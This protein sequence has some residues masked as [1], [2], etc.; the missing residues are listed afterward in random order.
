VDG[1]VERRGALEV[2]RVAGFDELGADVIVTTR[3]GGVSAPPYET[4]NLGDHVG[5]EP[6][7]VR[8]NRRRLASAMGVDLV[9]LA[10]ARQVHGTGVALLR[11]G[12]AHP[13]P[14]GDADVIVTDDA[15]LAIGVLVA[16]CVPIVVLDPV[17]GV[18][19]VAHAG[20]RGTA[21]RVAAVA[22]ETMAALGARPERC[23]AA[24]GPCISA[25]AYQVGEEV[26][27]ALR[28]AGCD[29]S[30]VPDGEGRYHADLATATRTHLI[31]AGLRSEHVALPTA[32][33]DDGTV[34]FSDR[35]ERPCGR[36][37]LAARLRAPSS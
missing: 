13:A 35:A 10:I 15:S 25:R 14:L 23:R 24:M 9:D 7:A 4:L 32:W 26:A 31:A 18:L 33:T 2:L 12:D 27:V 36:F 37:S 19:C 3:V 5:D 20:W 16:D 29:A 1:S 28:D 8:E 34:V 21:A 6:D 30:V 22:V 11:C 17:A